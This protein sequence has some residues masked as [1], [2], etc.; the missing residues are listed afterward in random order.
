M[1][2]KSIN[3]GIISVTA[4]VQTQILQRKHYFKDNLLSII[5]ARKSK[6]IQKSKENDLKRRLRIVYK[7][8][9]DTESDDEDDWTKCIY[10]CKVCKRNFTS[11]LQHIAKWSE[12]G[13]KYSQDDLNDLHFG[14]NIISNEN[15]KD[16]DQKEY[17]QENKG[18]FAER[19]QANKGAII[20]KYNEN[21]EDF[22]RRKRRSYHKNADK[23][24][25]T[26]AKYYQKNKAS[27]SEKNKKK[28]QD[29]KE[30]H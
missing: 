19:Y 3:T 20:K 5:M 6:Y 4:S 15:R 14:M 9:F 11:L 28:Y 13:Q 24:V 23:Y 10:I 7:E 16:R 2:F 17:Y 8:N 25:E 30:G 22:Q 21:K 1:K 18:K 12:C 27:I 26:R 29:K